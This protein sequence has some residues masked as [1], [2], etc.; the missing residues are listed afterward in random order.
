MK[1]ISF[2]RPYPYMIYRNI[3][4]LQLSASWKVVKVGDT[5]SDIK[6]AV[7][8]GVWAVGVLVGSSE[9]GLSHAEFEALTKADQKVIISETAEIFL[10][11]GADFTIR[12]M[13]E[14]PA[15]IEK[16]NFLVSEGKRP[17]TK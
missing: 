9:M 5:V 7:H 10:E 2:G 3:E 8:A 15:L 16:I 14:L 13:C 4:F 17:G 11:N 6:E 1:Q 12:S